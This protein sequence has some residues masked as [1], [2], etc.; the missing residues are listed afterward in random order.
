MD[1]I[2]KHPCWTVAI[3]G[4][5]AILLDFLSEQFAALG[6]FVAV[7]LLVAAVIAGVVLIIINMAAMLLVANDKPAAGVILSL[8]FGG[9]GAVIGTLFNPSYK[10]ENAVKIIFSMQL[11]VLIWALVSFMLETVGYYSIIGGFAP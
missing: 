5:L 8:P 7:W 2:K 4:I 3:I 6:L 9:L 11:W 1:F 10:Y